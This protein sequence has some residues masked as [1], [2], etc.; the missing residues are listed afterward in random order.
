MTKL[1]LKSDILQNILYDESSMN[2]SDKQHISLIHWDRRIDMLLRTVT[3]YDI[4][5]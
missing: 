1:V 3:D 5:D 4:S 2:E